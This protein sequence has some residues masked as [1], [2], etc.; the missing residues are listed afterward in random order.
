MPIPE[1]QL[2]TWSHQGAAIGS[3]TTYASVKSA[4]EYEPAN[5]T[6]RNFSVFLQ[7]S[8]GNDTNIFAESDVDVV[9]C[10]EGA[11]YRDL[12]QLSA[13]DKAAYLA[14]HG[15]TASYSY[16]SFKGH[17][18]EALRDSFGADVKPGTK[19]INILA[20]GSRRSADVIPAFNF[21]R[22]YRYK[23]DS[24]CGYFKGIS[25]FT[26]AAK[27]IDN[28]PNLHSGN[29]TTK[30]QATNGNFKPMIRIFKNI[31]GRLV[32]DGVLQKGDAPSYFIEGLL[33]NI[34][35]AQFTGT[36]SN[37]VYN[38]LKW[39]HDNPDHTKFVCV[40]ERYYLLRDNDS[41]CWPIADGA[42][43]IAAVTKLWNDCP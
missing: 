23:S 19:A 30:H 15:R 13:E 25:F 27:R 14:A 35:P 1:A 2:E 31:R 43:F 4:L 33:Y 34:P 42:K 5:Y 6:D 39:L 3:K 7:G 8:Y 37:M 22:Y 21:R 12:K 29:A 32:D 11:Y 40:N 9:I 20:N 28:F 41:V 36:Y 10:Y 38:I 16:D 26:S 24:D 18:E 17:V